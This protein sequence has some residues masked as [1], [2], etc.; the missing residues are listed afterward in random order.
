MPKVA[1][2][3]RL[4]PS[5]TKFSLSES[6]S[7]FLPNILL[8]PALLSPNSLNLRVLRQPAHSTP[9][10]LCLHHSC[11]LSEPWCT[12]W[13]SGYQGNL[14]WV[15]SNS[16]KLPISD[17]RSYLSRVPNSYNS[18]VSLVPRRLLVSLVGMDLQL[19]S[20]AVSPTELWLALFL[21]SFSDY[22]MREPHQM[23]WSRGQ[24]D[25]CCSATSPNLPSSMQHILCG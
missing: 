2:S 11:A 9:P 4:Q 3:K 13:L 23:A 16:T 12:W 15:R 8:R 7:F 6:S 20:S 14:W 19:L 18:I 22:G 17:L 21:W 25:I 1:H 5:G 24:R 10:D